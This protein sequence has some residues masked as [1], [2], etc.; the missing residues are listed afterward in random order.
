MALITV[1][2]ALPF[3]ALAAEKPVISVTEK[4]LDYADITW[5][6]DNEENYGNVIV[7]KSVDNK[8]WKKTSD[9]YTYENTVS[10]TLT[11]KKALYYR[12]KLYNTVLG[13]Y[14]SPS[15]SVLLY[16]NLGEALET[17][18][19]YCSTSPKKAVLYLSLSK[20]NKD[21]IN[22]FKIYKSVNGG[23]YKYVK[24][25]SVS[26]YK[27]KE[28]YSYTYKV[29][30]DAPSKNGYLVKFKVY[31]YFVYK[32]KTYQYKK[33]DT[34][35]ATYTGEGLVN[36]KTEKDKV[37]LN[38]KKLGSAK[39]KISY[40]PYNIKKKKYGKTKTVKTSEKKYTIKN[41][42]KNTKLD[43][44]I[45]PCW[46]ADTGEAV[47]LSSHDGI[48]LL[49]GAPKVKVKKIKII[50]V[51]KKKS[52]LYR[53]E[54]LTD[55]DKKIIK[56]FFYNKYKGKNPS[57]AE[58]AEYA[59]NWIHYK[60]KY[61]YK[62]TCGNLSYT[63][64]IFKKRKGQCRQYNGAMAKVLAYLGYES[65]IIYGT[66]KSGTQHFWCEVKLGGRWYLVETGNEDKN[67]DWQHFVTLYDDGLGYVK[68]K[69]AAKD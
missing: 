1:L 39:Y 61:D 21:Y 7:E 31:P 17:Y 42:S 52:K 66:R 51:K 33:L 41:K 26:D 32:G 50:N 4:G 8:T 46:G 2:T 19:C 63:E 20:N 6:I 24:K 16:S 49:S 44:E 22:G 68:N 65:R 54:T 48:A 18:G 27:T 62:Y 55:K 11:A 45:M 29:P 23:K 56:E 47:Y 67:S 59:F 13:T 64:A 25:L 10:V 3:T 9:F 28:K 38:L 40:T 12:I 14:T 15:K 5:S 57:R 53:T 35:N 43:F 37:V 60:V 58:M 30:T 69:K 34:I 36:I